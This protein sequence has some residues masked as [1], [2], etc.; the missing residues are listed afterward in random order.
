M[1][2][3]YGVCPRGFV[4]PSGTVV[5]MARMWNL[6]TKIVAL[7]VVLLLGSFLLQK[8]VHDYSKERLFEGV[9]VVARG[10]AAEVS[11]NLLD[12]VPDP[13]RSPVAK[14]GTGT[15]SVI[16]RFVGEGQTKATKILVPREKLSLPPLLV[17]S[18]CQQGNATSY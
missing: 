17:S 15:V 13:D 1:E 9:L 14:S 18:R 11:Q 12:S 6:Q 16:V 10:L 2:G 3:R 8:V 4:S 7:L 5:T